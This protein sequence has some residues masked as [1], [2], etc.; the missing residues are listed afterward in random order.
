LYIDIDHFKDVND[1]FGHATGDEVIAAVGRS[2]ANRLRRGDLMARYGGEEFVAVLPNT[3]LDEAVALAEEIRHLVA[4]SNFVA[5]NPPLQLHVSVGVAALRPGDDTQA[6]LAAADAA[7]YQAK[8]AGRDRV[9][10]APA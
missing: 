2:I 10:A 5:V 8:R 7:L 6:L 9:F 1:S 4:T 3:A